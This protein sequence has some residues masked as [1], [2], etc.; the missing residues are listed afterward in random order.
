MLHDFADHFSIDAF[1]T[2]QAGLATRRSAIADQRQRAS[3]T[4]FAMI[5]NIFA[6][7]FMAL[8]REMVQARSLKQFSHI[9][10]YGSNFAT[11]WGQLAGVPAV[12]CADL[13]YAWQAVENDLSR[14]MLELSNDADQSSTS[15]QPPCIEAQYQRF[16]S[17]VNSGNFEWFS[18]ALDRECFKTGRSLWLEFHNWEPVLGEI[19]GYGRTA[20]F[21]PVQSDHTSSTVLAN[22]E[23]SHET[24]IISPLSL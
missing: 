5:K 6:P 11:C 9:E 8:L 20:H 4:Y 10:G 1:K 12:S 18:V 16:V 24:G 7:A 19:H 3:A 23:P 13:Q 15:V 22:T 17:Q 21:V 14:L 2:L